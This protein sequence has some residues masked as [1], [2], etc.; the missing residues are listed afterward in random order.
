MKKL[1]IIFLAVAVAVFLFW[2]F[3]PPSYNQI[4]SELEKKINRGG[5]YAQYEATYYNISFVSTGYAVYIN[6]SWYN[7][8]DCPKFYDISPVDLISLLKK[9]S[10]SSVESHNRVYILNAYLDMPNGYIRIIASFNKTT[11]M[12]ISYALISISNKGEEVWYNELGR[13][14]TGDLRHVR[15][16]S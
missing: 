15:A 4:V 12:P 6:K 9:S 8:L 2:Y 1:V 7:F 16:T 11:G 14:R 10:I 13:I 3:W 5:G